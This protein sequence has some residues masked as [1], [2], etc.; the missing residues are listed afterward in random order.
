MVM[1]DFAH[2]F[3]FD[4]AKVKFAVREKFGFD[5]WHNSQTELRL[6]IHFKVTTL[7]HDVT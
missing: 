7:R 5:W 4:V 1:M 3:E 2:K 6:G